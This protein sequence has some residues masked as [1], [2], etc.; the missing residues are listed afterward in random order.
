MAKPVEVPEAIF[1]A[2]QHIRETALIR[3]DSLFAPERKLWIL[4]I[5]KKFHALFVE[6]F[7]IGAGSFL[8][9]L[10]TQMEGA[11]DDLFQLAAELLYVQ[12][13]FTSVTGAEKKLENVRAVLAWCKQPPSIPK[14]A[15]D[16]LS[17]GLA[18]DQSFNQHRPFH[19]DDI[20]ERIVSILARRVIDRARKGLYRG[21]IGESDD[22][23]Y[24]R[25]TI[26][27]LGAV[28]N[29]VRGI[30]K[31]PCSYEEHTADLKENQI[32][33]WTLNQ[34]RRQALVRDK[35]KS[36]LDQARRVLAGTISFQRFLP[37]DCVQKFYHRLNYDYQPMHGLCRF[38]LEQTGPGIHAGDRSFFPFEVNMPLLFQSFA[39][40]WL[41]ANAPSGITIHCK[42]RAQLDANYEMQIEIDILLIEESSHKAIA[43]LDTKYKTSELPPKDDIHQIAF[44]AGELHVDHGMFVY[45]SS[46]AK[47]FHMEHANKVTI[48]SLVF[49]IGRAPEVAG[50]AFLESLKRTLASRQS[51]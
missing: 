19:L 1:V 47:Q 42:H 25:G 45:P 36:E 4:D 39:A 8:E 9:K 13:F 20:Y 7:D 29:T 21:Y 5:L 50:A 43:V 2:L 11:G 30:A 33:C 22:L 26:D 48:E 37:K 51:S 27:M 18:R 32:L 46:V 3:Y 31:I 49:D 41:R 28:L 14:W 34:V 15:V 24:M 10:Q 17:W 35:V 23:P 38:I 40:E 16:G 12:Q 44:Y 6:R